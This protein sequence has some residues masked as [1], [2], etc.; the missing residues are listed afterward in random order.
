MVGPLQSTRL[1]GS[2][3]KAMPVVNQAMQSAQGGGLQQSPGMMEVKNQ[4]NVSGLSNK[5]PS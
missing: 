1:I 4:I 3:Q 2:K 5:K